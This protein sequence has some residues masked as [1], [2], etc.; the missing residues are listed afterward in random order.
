MEFL[1]G[2]KSKAEATGPQKKVVVVGGGLAGCSV[3][4]ALKGKG[5]AVTL[6]DTKDYCDWCLAS[7]RAYVEEFEQPICFPLAPGS[8]LIEAIGRRAC[9]TRRS[10]SFANTV[11]NNFAFA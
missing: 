4:K 8:T 1:C 10:N 7:P 3:L 9:R 11:V 5:V 2:S 6:V